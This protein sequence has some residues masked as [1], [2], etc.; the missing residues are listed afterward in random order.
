MSIAHEKKFMKSYRLPYLAYYDHGDVDGDDYDDDDDDVYAV[1]LSQT[2]YS[3]SLG[4]SRAS[5]VQQ[6]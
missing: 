1:R 3:R 6:L 2:P 5:P 4:R